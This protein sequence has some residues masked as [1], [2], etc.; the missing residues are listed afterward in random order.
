MR[1]KGNEKIIPE[2]PIIITI[3]SEEI[4]LNGNYEIINQDAL[5]KIKKYDI[6]GD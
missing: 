4:I 5:E 1:Y 6:N 2:Y 3:D